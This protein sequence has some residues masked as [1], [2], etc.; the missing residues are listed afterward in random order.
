[1]HGHNFFPQLPNLNDP[2][3]LTVGSNY[4]GVCVFTD[5]KSQLNYLVI[6]M[7]KLQLTIGTILSLAKTITAVVFNGAALQKETWKRLAG[8]GHFVVNLLDGN[9]VALNGKIRPTSR[10][11]Y[12][13]L[14]V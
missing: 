2:S 11:C 4:Q 5:D 8:D 10:H 14:T 9:S 1:V 3:R 6:C 12:Q 13:K 7:K